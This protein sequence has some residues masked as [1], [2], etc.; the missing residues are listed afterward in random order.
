MKTN[1]YSNDDYQMASEHLR[2]TLKL[3]SRYQIP[4]S[5]LNFRIGY[6]YVVGISEELNTSLDETIEQTDGNLAEN[7][8][9]IYQRFYQQ[10]DQALEK[11][12]QELRHIIANIQN[13]FTH[14]GGN[15]SN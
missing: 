1:P 8:W 9:D 5:P 13:E 7:L 12:R 10:E 15:L 6:D 4:P 2:L 11:I 14:S 3:L